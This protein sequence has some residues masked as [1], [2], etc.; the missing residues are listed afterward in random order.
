[1]VTSYCPLFISSRWNL[2]QR[3]NFSYIPMYSKQQTESPLSAHSLFFQRQFWWVALH[4]VKPE[5]SK[6]QEL[7]FRSAFKLFKNILAWQG[8]LSDALL[9]E[10]ALDRLL[11]RCWFMG[12]I[13][14]ENP[15]TIFVTISWV[16]IIIF[17]YL[18]LSVRANRDALDS[19]DKARQILQVFLQWSWLWSTWWVST[20]QSTKVLPAWWLKPGSS[21]MGKL[22]MLSKWVLQVGSEQGM[23][24]YFLQ[25][26]DWSVV[27]FVILNH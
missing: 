26:R 1:M 11:N 21:E 15:I 10:L 9:V 4:H 12:I 6:I 8:T 18:L 25:T 22:G 13:S 20:L 7:C 23:P 27:H 14:G 2:C 16:N 5:N 3:S 17:R 24:R 19:V